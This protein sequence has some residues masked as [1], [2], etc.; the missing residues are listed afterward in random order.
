MKI[1]FNK[2]SPFCTAILLKLTYLRCLISYVFFIIPF[3]ILEKRGKKTLSKQ[4]ILVINTDQMGDLVLANDFISSVLLCTRYNKKYILIPEDYEKLFNFNSHEIIIIN[5]NRRKYKFNPYYR[6]KKI[7]QI[8]NLDLNLVL[9]ITHERGII[10]DELTLLSGAKKSICLKENSHYLPHFILIRNNKKYSDILNSKKKNAYDILSDLGVFLDIN[11][12]KN[13]NS[14]FYDYS[15]KNL[16]PFKNV[17]KYIVI[18]ASASD[19]FRNWPSEN[20]HNLAK[21]L[22]KY[23]PVFL[24]GTLSQKKILNK[25]SSNLDNVFN[26]AGRYELGELPAIIKNAILFIG[27][28]SGLSHL[29]LQLNMPSIAIIGGGKIGE[30]FH[31]KK[32]LM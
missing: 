30:F 26:F 28:D 15:I 2:H 16:L 4:N 11:L 29:A 17:S 14:F 1:F 24:L 7:I 22:S 13:S 20:F 31:I 9:N 32:V 5:F 3:I 18:S 19:T 8:Q 21:E 12:K 23:Y 6:I 25:I 10:N 27:L